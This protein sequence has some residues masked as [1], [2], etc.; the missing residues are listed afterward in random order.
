MKTLIASGAILSIAAL[1]P[2]L[3][4]PE[5]APIFNWTGFYIGG[6]LGGGWSD[7]SAKAALTG[8]G[9]FDPA[10]IANNASGI[11]GG[12]QIGYN[13]QFTSNWLLGIEGDL[14]GTNIHAFGTAPF[15]SGGIPY[16]PELHH[17]ATRDINWLASIRGRLGYTSNHWLVYVTGGGA[18]GSINYRTNI[19]LVV[20]L[21]PQSFDTTS[22]G[23][24]IGGG[25]EYAVTSNWTARVEYL[26][27]DFGDTTV[28]NVPAA[29]PNAALITTFNNKIDVVRAGVNYKF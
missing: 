19:T 20:P 18:W 28:A 10:V 25:V 15:A 14:S 24:V 23:G 9:A 3:A 4:A 8:A 7:D 12:G 11:V 21:T 17:E 16:P 1:S 22:S 27:Y 2:A 5:A 6:H 29:A 26:H 13:W